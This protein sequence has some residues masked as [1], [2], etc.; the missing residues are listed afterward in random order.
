MITNSRMMLS[1]HIMLIDIL[2]RPFYRFAIVAEQRDRDQPFIKPVPIYGTI[3]F[4]KNKREVVADSLNTSFGNLESSTRQWIEKKLM[5][6][7]DEYHER[8]LLVQR[9]HS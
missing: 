4:N 3:T 8:Q 7:I 9:K 1:G 6:E 2:N 5:K